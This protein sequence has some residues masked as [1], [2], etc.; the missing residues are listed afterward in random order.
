MITR[1]IFSFVLHIILLQK[2]PSHVSQSPI[3]NLRSRKNNLE[4]FPLILCQKWV[5]FVFSMQ[6]GAA[7]LAFRRSG[8][9][10]LFFLFHDTSITTLNC[11]IAALSC[12]A[13]ALAHCLHATYFRQSCLNWLSFN[14]FH[15][16]SFETPTKHKTQT[17]T[18]KITIKLL[19]KY[20]EIDE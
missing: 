19:N 12:G 13:A 20:G 5:T 16:L 7:A 10:F 6:A 3:Y 15:R 4:Q 9:N 11:G 8:A 14:S 1:V 17:K 18:K 2:A